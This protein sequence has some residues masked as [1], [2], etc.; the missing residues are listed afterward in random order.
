[1][2][3]L[4][5]L[6]ISFTAWGQAPNQNTI[7]A[8]VEAALQ[9]NPQALRSARGRFHC[10]FDIIHSFEGRGDTME[11]AQTRAQLLCIREQCEGSDQRQMES[12]ERLRAQS[13]EELGYLLESIGHAR[14]THAD[15]IRNI[16]GQDYVAGSV[17]CRNDAY[18]RMIAFDSCFAVPMRCSRR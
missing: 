18:E 4:W 12:L 11:E 8:Y 1:M 16:R 17:S 15:T 3:V 2:R 10:G 14:E 13:D 7:D 9:A 5:L 6:L